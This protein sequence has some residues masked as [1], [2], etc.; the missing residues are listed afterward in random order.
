MNL[1]SLYNQLTTAKN[2][3]TTHP[4]KSPT[5]EYCLKCNAHTLVTRNEDGSYT[6]LDCIPEHTAHII[7][8]SHDNAT[9]SAWIDCLEHLTKTNYINIDTQPDTP[10][11]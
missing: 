1:Q 10:R 4:E 5:V 11:Q 7:E 2:A 8:D 9:L 3:R 6:H